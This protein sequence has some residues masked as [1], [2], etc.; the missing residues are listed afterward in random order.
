ME[1][2]YNSLL[3]SQNLYRDQYSDEISKLNEKIGLLELELS[4]QNLNYDIELNLNK[5]QDSVKRFEIS[6]TEKDS[7]LSKIITHL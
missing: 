7:K 1:V 5:I 2:N 6:E 3:E 4:N